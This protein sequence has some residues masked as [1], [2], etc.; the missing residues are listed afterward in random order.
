LAGDVGLAG[1]ALGVERVELLPQSLPR[2]TCGC[3]PR[4]AVCG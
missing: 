2:W 4:S 1:L 3:T